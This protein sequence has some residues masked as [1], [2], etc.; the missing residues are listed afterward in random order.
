MLYRAN[1]IVFP[2][3]CVKYASIMTS[4]SQ[5]RMLSYKEIKWSVQGEKVF[6][7]PWRAW[8]RQWAGFFLPGPCLLPDGE[9]RAEMEGGRWGWC[10]WIKHPESTT[11]LFTLHEMYWVCNSSLL[12][13]KRVLGWACQLTGEDQWGQVATDAFLSQAHNQHVASSTKV[14]RALGHTSTTMTGRNTSIDFFLC[15]TS[16]GKREHHSW[17]WG[18]LS[19]TFRLIR[20]LFSL[21][22][23]FSTINSKYEEL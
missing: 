17:I 22:V 16:F 2:N 20:V 14:S 7:R 4:T 5:E 19:L 15:I 12:F 10:C 11:G 13:P 6:A 9:L 3:N 18:M 21:S 8:R 23:R 1:Q